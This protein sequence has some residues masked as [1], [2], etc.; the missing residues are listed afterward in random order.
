MIDRFCFA[1]KLFWPFILVFLCHVFHNLNC[2]PTIIVKLNDLQPSS[3]IHH[4]QKN[5][6]YLNETNILQELCM[7]TLK[8]DLGSAQHILA[9]KYWQDVPSI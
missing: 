4:L 9:G 5:D 7:L 1:T 8:S 2:R 6:G 3:W